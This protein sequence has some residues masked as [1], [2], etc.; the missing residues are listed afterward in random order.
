MGPVK[1]GQELYGSAHEAIV[2]QSEKFSWQF[3][4]YDC[5]PN[6]MKKN[7]DKV[8]AEIC[9][10]LEPLQEDIRLAAAQLAR[11]RALLAK[12]RTSPA[13]GK[14][15]WYHSPDEQKP[16]RFYLGPLTDTADKLDAA[17]CPRK[18]PD[19]NH[20]QLKQRGTDGH[21]WI[22]RLRR[23]CF[24]VWF[25]DQGSF[26]AG[27]GGS[28][29]DNGTVVGNQRRGLPDVDRTKRLPT[30]TRP[31]GRPTWN[32]QRRRMGAA[33]RMLPPPRSQPRDGKRRRTSRNATA[34]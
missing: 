12:R 18:K 26:T 2:A 24:E 22:V 33:N 5:N 31:I 10:F 6:H 21:L 16:D 20:R 32:I 8:R 1:L 3:A 7:L 34:R 14:A 11:E 29:D 30:S 17:I 9:G 15:P 13:D 19:R 25:L 23:T 27:R 4:R 28:G